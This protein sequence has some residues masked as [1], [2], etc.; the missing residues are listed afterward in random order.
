MHPNCGALVLF[1]TYVPGRDGPV[2][3]NFIKLN[4][5]VFPSRWT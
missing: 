1:T 3:T 4:S 2:Q 5:L